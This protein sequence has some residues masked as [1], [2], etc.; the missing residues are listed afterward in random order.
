MLLSF[1]SESCPSSQAAI[2]SRPF[3]FKIATTLLQPAP[4]FLTFTGK[5]LTVKPNGFG[6]APKLPK[7]SIWQYSRLRPKKMARP[8]FAFVLGC[9]KFF[10][11]QKTWTVKAD[12]V[13]THHFDAIIQA[14]ILSHQAYSPHIYLRNHQFPK[15]YPHRYIK[16]RYPWALICN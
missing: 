15:A 12:G 11:H 2:L 16:E 4:A 14:N 8:N 5:Q 10:E 3:F 13:N 9:Q 7:R 1:I 6:I